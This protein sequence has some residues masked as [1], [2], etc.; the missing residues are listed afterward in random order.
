MT[1]CPSNGKSKELVEPE[2]KP[3]NEAPSQSAAINEPEDSALASI[4]RPSDNV[5]GANPEAETIALISANS[6]PEKA[7]AESRSPDDIGEAVSDGKSDTKRLLSPRRAVRDSKSGSPPTPA[8]A[9][10][11]SSSEDDEGLGPS[12]PAPTCSNGS[13]SEVGLKRE[14]ES[15]EK[16]HEDNVVDP[17]SDDEGD[18][19]LGPAAPAVP[20]ALSDPQSPA[21]VAPRS[22]VVHS[23]TKVF[24]PH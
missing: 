4:E 1:P 21:L 14:P 15:A 9:E 10:N 2:R 13:F 6:A 17:S 24:T 12:L 18:G 19:E 3:R 22:V 16:Q 8:S 5:S 20:A 23:R 11:E 7:H